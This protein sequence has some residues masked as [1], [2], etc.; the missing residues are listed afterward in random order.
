M[1]LGLEMSLTLLENTGR[2]KEG[3]IFP[4]TINL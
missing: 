3:Y 4:D 1:R 2:L